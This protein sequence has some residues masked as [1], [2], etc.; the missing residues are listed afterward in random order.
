LT[1]LTII[2]TVHTAVWV[3]FNAVLAYLAYAAIVNRIDVW[4]WIGL[5]LFALE[6][7]VLLVFKMVCPLTVMARRYSASAKNNFDIYL[8]EWLAKYN[9]EI[10]SILLGIVIILIVY[11]LVTNS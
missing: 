1:R 11:R 2:K 6:G 5:S 7:I 3:F 9:K 4:V 8:P 10:Y